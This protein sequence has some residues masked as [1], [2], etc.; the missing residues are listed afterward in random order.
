MC[1]TIFLERAQDRILKIQK[2]LRGV[3][4][5]LFIDMKNTP[6]QEYKTNVGKKV[7][8]NNH[9]W[10]ANP[11][12]FRHFL[13]STRQTDPKNVEKVVYLGKESLPSLT[14]YKRNTCVFCFNCEKIRGEPGIYIEN[15]STPTTT[16]S[17]PDP[18]SGPRPRPRHFE[19]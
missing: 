17:L 4:F 2:Y 11:K 1:Q 10:F 3:F 12:Y 19:P 13:L 15:F 5:F 9:K 14:E 16:L 7:K 8:N 6:Q 18:K